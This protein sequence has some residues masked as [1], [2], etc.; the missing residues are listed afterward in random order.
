MTLPKSSESL[1]SL[2]QISLFGITTSREERPFMISEGQS[3]ASL[4]SIQDICDILDQV[5]SILDDD[6]ELA[7]KNAN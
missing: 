7:K 2:A 5:L 6:T 4:L 3:E 1:S